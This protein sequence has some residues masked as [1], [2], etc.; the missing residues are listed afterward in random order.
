MLV[1][2]NICPSVSLSLTV[3][4]SI[5]LSIVI[6]IMFPDMKFIILYIR[7]KLSTRLTVGLIEEEEILLFI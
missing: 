2:A 4:L 1:N 5:T 3:S 6:N 7:D